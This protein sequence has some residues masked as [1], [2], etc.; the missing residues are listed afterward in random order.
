VRSKQTLIFLHEDPGFV[1]SHLLPHWDLTSNIPIILYDQ[2][3]NR[4]ST[5]LKEKAPEFW[6]VDL[7]IAEL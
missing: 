2:L 7:F 3:G 1:H 6:S 4:R 5:Y